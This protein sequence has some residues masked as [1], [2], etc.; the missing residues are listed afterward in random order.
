MRF[1]VPAGTGPEL[2]FQF[3]PEPDRNFDCAILHLRNMFFALYHHLCHLFIQK[4]CSPNSETYMKKKEADFFQKLAKNFY[5]FTI[6]WN[7]FS[8]LYQFMK[9]FKTVWKFGNNAVF[10]RILFRPEPMMIPAGTGTFLKS[11][12]NSGTSLE[13]CRPARDSTNPCFTR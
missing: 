10:K 6:I 12:R 11:G 13:K 9:Q 7:C 3:R 5:F 2:D 4:A 1:W 8:Q